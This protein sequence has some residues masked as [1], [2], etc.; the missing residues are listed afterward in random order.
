MGSPH[1]GSKTHPRFCSSLLQPLPALPHLGAR[2]KSLPAIHVARHHSSGHLVQGHLGKQSRQKPYPASCA[3][4]DK[5][6]GEK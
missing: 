4:W 1:P 2:H 3:P 5:R 6:W